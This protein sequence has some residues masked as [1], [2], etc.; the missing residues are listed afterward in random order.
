MDTVVTSLFVKSKKRSIWLDQIRRDRRV[1][2]LGFR[3]AF[4]LAADAGRDNAISERLVEF[5][6]RVGV[7][8]ESLL[9]AV[10]R[11]SRLGYVTFQRGK[12]KAP[13]RIQISK[14]P[15]PNSVTPS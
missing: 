9:R 11:L 8:P 3:I 1:P 12:Y 4:I 13:C 6:D 10:D 2:N 14:R 15:A 7:A 5:A